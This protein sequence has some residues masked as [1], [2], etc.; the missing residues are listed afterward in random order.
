MSL[1]RCDNYNTFDPRGEVEPRFF[2]LLSK[3][4]A[5]NGGALSKIKL[6]F[7]FKVCDKKIN[8]DNGK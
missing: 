4:M 1:S 2:P 3:K 8:K 6:H 5:K 7:E